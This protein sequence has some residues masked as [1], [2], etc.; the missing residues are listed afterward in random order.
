MEQQRESPES[1]HLHG[2]LVSYKSAKVI[3]QRKDSFFN[4]GTEKIRHQYTKN[5]FIPNTT[6]K[7]NLK[8]F[9]DLNVNRKP[10][11][12]KQKP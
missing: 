2:P 3:Q 12:Y 4:S 6:L 5:E 7:I 10:Y 1:P 11:K 9:I 8:L